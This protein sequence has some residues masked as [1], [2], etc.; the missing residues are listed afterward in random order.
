MADAASW[1]R[2]PETRKGGG[3]TAFWI[4]VVTELWLIRLD[5]HASQAPNFWEWLVALPACAGLL[6]VLIYGYKDL[7]TYEECMRA[8]QRPLAS[9]YLTLLIPLPFLLPTV[10]P[11][12]IVL[13]YAIAVICGVLFA[14][15]AIVLAALGGSLGYWI[16]RAVPRKAAG[17]PS[18]PH[19]QAQ[20]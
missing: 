8:A 17:A 15:F 19:V 20:S 12:I 2:F 13:F 7:R 4:T 9:G 10:R 6:S 16:Q 14:P 18:M 5:P 3:R 1:F 11:N